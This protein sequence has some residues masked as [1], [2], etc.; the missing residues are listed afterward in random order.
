MKL[1]KILQII[2]LLFIFSISPS[3]THATGINISLTIRDEDNIVFEG[4][5]PLQPAGSID[6][7]GHQLDA[8]SVLSVLNDA[9][10]SSDSFQISDLEYYDSMNS[11]YLKCITDSSGNKCENWQYTINDA[12]PGVGMD[13]NILSGGEKVYVYFGQN[14]KITLSSSSIKSPDTLTVKTENYQYKDNTWTPLAGVTVGLTQPDPGNPFSPKEIKTG[15]TDTNGQTTFNEI[16]PGSYDVG[17]KEDYYF[18]TQKLVVVTTPDPG[19]TPLPVSQGG[20]GGGYVAPKLK[21]V[22]DLKRALDFLSSQQ[23]TDSSFGESI[24]TDWT[25]L[26]LASSSDYQTQ[27]E[28]LKKYFV[29]KKVSSEQLTD[30]ERHAMT[31]M[32]LDLNPYNT[33]NENYIE[34]IIKSFDGKQFGDVNEDNDDIFALIVLQNAGYGENDKIIQ[35]D[36]NFI[37]SKQK[38]DGSWDESVDLTGASIE[39]LSSFQNNLA[40]KNNLEKAGNFL[41]QNQKETGGWNNV[42][43][44]AWAVEGL[45]ALGEKPTDSILDYFAINQD[46]DGGTKDENLNNRIWGT[47]YVATSLSGKTWN[48]IMQKF[49]KPPIIQ[50]ITTKESTPKTAT[51]KVRK[52]TKNKNKLNNLTTIASLN[53]ATALDAL[54]T[55]QPVK[56][57]IPEIPK[58]QNWFKRI[59]SKLFGF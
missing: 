2:L 29:E 25:T 41:K 33:N 38:A 37:L 34:K 51:L 19:P 9:D 55:N 10:I 18:P 49:E 22:F 43:A 42:S 8:D 20:N 27:K 7:N 54:N 12:S 52:I 59:F 57:I 32:S 45:L 35:D 23:K 58:K 5:I 1:K 21:P 36:L 50:V 16:D 53:T 15:T 48:Q 4:D 31:L 47:A 39:A 40:V 24:Y 6:L 26:A 46:V 13:K 14:H 30:Y 11:F 17:I 28:K 44:T 3:P 56:S